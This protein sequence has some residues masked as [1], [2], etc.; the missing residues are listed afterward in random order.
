MSTA[1]SPSTVQST[2]MTMRKP[3]LFDFTVTRQ[4]TSDK[5]NS[6]NHGLGL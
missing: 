2:R 4:P 5:R 1:I 3:Q 6:W